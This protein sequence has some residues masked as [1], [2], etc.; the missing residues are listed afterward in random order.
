MIAPS[1]AQSWL[2]GG[3]ECHLARAISLDF[4]W[5]RSKMMC[6]RMRFRNA[7][8][9]RLFRWCSRDKHT[10][11][12][13]LLEVDGISERSKLLNKVPVLMGYSNTQYLMEQERVRK[14]S[15][16]ELISVLK[17]ID[18]AEISAKF[19]CIKIGD[20]S[21]IE[22]YD[23]SANMKCNETML[24]GNLTNFILESGGNLETNDEFADK[25]HP[26]GPSLANVNDLSISE[27]SSLT[28]QH[29]SSERAVDGEVCLESLP[30]A[31]TADGTV[32]D[33]NR[34]HLPGES[35]V[36]TEA[37][38]ESLPD[39]TSPDNNILDKDIRSLPGTT[40]KQ[41]RKL[42]DGGFHTIRKL[43]QHFPRT[44]A[45]LQNPQDLI[46]DGQ[47][48]MF[49]GTVISSKGVRIRSTLGFVEV[50]VGCSIVEA[51]LSSSDV[52]CNSGA[53]QKQ[54]IHLHLKKF[55]SGQRFSSQYFLNCIS[56]KHKEGD[57]VYVSGKVKKVLSS[58]HYDLKE[59]TIDKL[60][61]EEQQN[62][63][64]DRKPYPIYPS[65]AGLEARLLGQSISRAL[66]MLTP[67]IDPIPLEVLTEFNLANL[68]D[69]YMGI[70]KPK[71][72]DE[73]DFARRRLIFDDFFYL[74]L[75]RLFQMLEAVGTRVEKEELLYKCENHE[76][77]AV[78]VNQWSPLANK[79]LKA[80]PY[81]LTASQLNAVKEIIWDLR[82]PV[83]MNRLLQGD[84]GCGKTIVAFLACMEVVNSGFQAA[85]MVPTEVL[86]VQHYE[87]LTSLLE[88]LDGD[89]CKPNIALLTGSTSTRESR[90][91]RN[92]LK[93]GEISMVIGTHTLIADKTDFS[94]LRISV[95]D[96]QQRFGVIQRG[97]FNNKLYTSSSKLSDEDTSADVASDSETFMAPHVLA[98]SATPIPRTLA[99][100]LYGDMSLTQITDLPPGRQPI[101]TLALEGN[102][103]GFETVFQMMRDELIDGGKVY[104]VYPI[105]E[106]SEHLPQLH[107]AK[108]DFDS[109][110]QKFE[111]Y[112]CGLLHGRMKGNEKDEALGS[113]RSGETR[114]LLATQVIEIGVD[115]PDASMMI[116]MNAER[117]GMS[118]LH[119]LRGRVGRG[120]KK[121]RC[122][123]LSST[124][125]TLPRL[126]VLENSSDGFHLAN[127]DLVMRG[128]GNL[129]GKKQ[130]GH[131]PEF[132]IARL[133]IDGGILQEAH[134][135]ALKVLGTSNDLSMFPRLKVELS[136]RQP[137]CL[138]GD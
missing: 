54:R 81:S 110:K 129:L 124:S 38:P 13:K 31:A 91:I 33:K 30:D 79:L 87:H 112:P 3:S 25:C 62:A 101:E 109:I 52:S 120:G 94:A 123:F 114:I 18:F 58:G 93:T 48:I 55:F 50:V 22:L 105:I 37:C 42:E 24:S 45:D 136:M 19:P 118:Q 34:R 111:G 113:F 44:Y 80:L 117:F 115:I 20:S 15:A 108:A 77:N 98:M 9:S 46:E 130:S 26:L 2:K 23:D 59:Y 122:V 70:H 88:K 100:A 1:S 126:K 137:L 83:P 71:N 86:A 32:L 73:A 104:L 135:A 17:E 11:V 6:S 8:G 28:T 92:G 56:S 12:R 61:E 49:F 72:R 76:L 65:K 66:K 36:V 82:R 138:L 60:E 7:L 4:R 75:G 41:Y 40:S 103:A 106:E 53:E 99:L 131:L 27:E 107:A 67:D 119:Q 85:F 16:T 14:E 29:I 39:A 63:L 78:D 74:Q 134:L 35:A 132:P 84:V 89:E 102:D 128:P 43:L 68:F 121:S 51:E 10:S 64:L 57:I 97:R 96:E 133:E 116:V 125:S 47:Y 90:I 95:I 69:A 21:P 5:G 127:A